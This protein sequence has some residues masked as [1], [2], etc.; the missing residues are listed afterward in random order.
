[1]VRV[2]ADHFFCHGLYP[3][4][5]FSIAMARVGTSHSQHYF[6]ESNFSNAS[7]GSGPAVPPAG[8]YLE[9]NNNL[10]RH[11]CHRV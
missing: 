3:H 5:P 11:P 6:L 7:A 2:Y 8:N 10:Y 9:N 4:K 1:M